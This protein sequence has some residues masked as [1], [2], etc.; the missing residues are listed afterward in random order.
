MPEQG[1][2]RQRLVIAGFL[3][4]FTVFV[5]AV[6]FGVLGMT[7][8]PT[9][10]PPDGV[11]DSTFGAGKPPQG[12]EPEPPDPSSSASRPPSPTGTLP[13]QDTGDLLAL[14]PGDLQKSCTPT[15]GSGAGNVV[16]LNCYPS[17]NGPALLALFAYTDG[18]GMMSAFNDDFGDLPSGSCS[19]GEPG[20]QTWT[21]SG[22][23]QGPLACYTSSTDDAVIVW[24]SNDKAVLAVAQ[25]A[26]WTP[27]QMY[28]WWLND[29]PNL[30]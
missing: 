2:R 5:L 11:A 19:T 6:A 23:T 10:A 13:T 26:D 3:G 4:T 29:A 14:V 25:D 24:G 17:G 21:Y 28:N 27:S 8:N 15:P 18:A 1:S 22:T 16:S 20:Q 30:Q 9:A 12:A 7:S